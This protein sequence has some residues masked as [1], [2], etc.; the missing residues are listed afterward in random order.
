MGLSMDGRGLDISSFMS[1][2]TLQEKISLLGGKERSHI[3][4]TSC[5]DAIVAQ[6]AATKDQAL[7]Q[8]RV[9]NR[10]WRHTSDAA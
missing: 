6:V 8:F 1:Q 10:Q 5:Q 9:I 2:L 4:T 3:H 7:M